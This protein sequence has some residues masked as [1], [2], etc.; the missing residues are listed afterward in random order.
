MENVYILLNGPQPICEFGNPLQFN[1]FDLGYR[2]GCILGNKCKCVNN[3]RVTNQK[4]TLKEKY[5]VD[6]VNAIPGV[7]K[8]RCDTMLQKHGVQYAS[9]STTVKEKA[10]ITR[11]KRTI[12][13]KQKSYQKSVK[14]YMEKYGVAHHMMLE[15]QQSKVHNT[16]INRYF[17]KVPLQNAE[18]A[19][20]SSVKQQNKSVEEKNLTL[21]KTK[22]SIYEKYNVTAASR[23]GIP[24]EVLEV[25]DNESKF[26]N[27][28]Q[29]KTRKEVS[30]ELNIANHTV[31]LY[32]KK[33]NIQSL[34]K[35]DTSSEPE[36]EINEF[37]NSL[38]ISTETGNRTLLKG[39]EIDIFIPQLNV[40]IEHCGL[41]FHSEKSANK[42]KQYHYNK[43]KECNY[44]GI[45]L[46]TIFGDEWQNQQQKV[47]HRLTHILNKSKQLYARKC[48]VNEIST[49]DAAHFIN[50]YH[51]QGYSS[52]SYKLGLFYNTELVAVMTFGKPRYNKKYEWEL[53]RFCSSTAIA[54]GA[55]KL[56]Q[57]FIKSKTPVSVISYSD[58]RWGSGKLYENLKMIKETETIGFFYTDYVNRYNR[59]QFQKHKLITDELKQ[60]EQTLDKIWDCG[61][62]RWCWLNNTII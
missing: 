47:K 7:N 26:S 23:I 43:Y 35:T 27:F 60:K 4:K 62:S 19:K 42:S 10:A 18:I 61:Q 51:L 50:E 31:Y 39:K 56:F 58:N 25:L 16:N 55:S 20:K 34:F 40:A 45:T 11:S 49:E 17:A 29:G 13:Q 12:E 15:S 46:I 14:T 57:F 8:K 22:D 6:T 54:G 44:Q 36:R 48:E 3:Q 52:A 28:I 24:L 21:K 59:T 41:Y 53:L 9:Q 33:Y 32:A 2:K 37:I 5:G 38:G 30:S 1:T